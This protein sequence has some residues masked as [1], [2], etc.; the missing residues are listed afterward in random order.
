MIYDHGFDIY[1]FC[2]PWF[3]LWDFEG[4]LRC[5][6]SCR[7]RWIN[8][9][10]SDLKRGNISS[11]EEETII[12]LHSSKG[13]RLVQQSSL[14][15]FLLHHQAK[16]TQILE[17]LSPSVG[18][19]GFITSSLVVSTNNGLLFV[20]DII[21]FPFLPTLLWWGWN[22]FCFFLPDFPSVIS[23]ST[24]SLIPK[25]VSLCQLLQLWS[26][27][28]WSSTNWVRPRLMFD[29]SIMHLTYFQARKY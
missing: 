16:W 25:I 8:Y 15:I 12:K 14:F 2:F 6:K 20:F 10:R 28:K 23:S 21:C 18:K 5:G 7:L 27:K 3:L 9:L 24:S 26:R 13:N 22:L 1:V 4:L 29:N 17:F 19:G 11:E